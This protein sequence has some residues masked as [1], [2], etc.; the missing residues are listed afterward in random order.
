MF[1]QHLK[2]QIAD[3]QA[4]LGALQATEA[5]LDRSTAVIRFD[6]DARVITAN[7]NFLRTMGYTSLE[8]VAGQPHSIFCDKPYTQSS[9]Y[10]R[11]W[12]TLKRGEHFSGRVKRQNA[13]GQTV[14]LEAT[15]NPVLDSQGR[16]S[17]FI[18]LASDITAR[19]TAAAKDRA[20]L[21]ALNRAMAVIE[22]TPDGQIVQANDNFLQTLGYRQTDLQGKHHRI[23][24]DASYANSPEYE[25][26][27]RTLRSGQYFS[28]QIERLDSRGQRLFLEASYNPVFDDSGNVSGVVK[29]AT[30]I[31]DKILQV[32]K[33][34]DTALFALTSSQQTQALSASG[35]N[36]IQQSVAE[37]GAMAGSIEQ[38]G[39]NVQALGE[40]SQAIT[41]IVQTIKD[42]ADQ[43]NLLA[44]NAAIEA[45]RAGEMGRGF[46]VVA[47]EVRKLAERT[48]SS[49]AEIASM[50]GDIQQ[51]TRTAVENMD[52]ILLQA[53]DNVT[54][55]QRTGDT[56]QQISDGA[57]K[58]VAAI[59]QFTHLKN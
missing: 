8:Q 33:E 18:K 4:Q 44:L 15:Y 42:I 19:V 48:S 41:S 56:M 17:G 53:R 37:I 22:F 20:T 11:F 43:T 3:L 23:F 45:A 2:K 6:L 16:V 55:T 21:A 10:A 26:L 9:D 28:G 29:F 35:V 38:A 25:Q 30:N 12:E 24:C 57:E 59:S 47:D 5:A 32:Q 51:Q 46:A 50:V 54:L 52:Q 14:W 1:N 39:L 34:R 7:A 31:T 58:V 49:T 40:R 36:N 13:Q 27:W